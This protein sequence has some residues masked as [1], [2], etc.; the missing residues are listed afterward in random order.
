MNSTLDQQFESACRSLR[1]KIR[2][3]LAEKPRAFGNFSMKV[4]VQDGRIVLL[5]TTQSETEKP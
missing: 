2:K 1:E 3:C 5:E 4:T